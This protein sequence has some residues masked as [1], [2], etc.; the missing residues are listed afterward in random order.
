MAD[1][2]T[3]PVLRLDK[4]QSERVIRDLQLRLILFQIGGL[5]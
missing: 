3:S 5:G 2:T 1:L 4:S